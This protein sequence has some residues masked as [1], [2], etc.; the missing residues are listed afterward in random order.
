ML[1]QCWTMLNNVEQC[2]TMSNNVE[3]CWTMLSHVK[4]CWAMLNDVEPCWTMLNHVESCWTRLLCFVQKDVV[5]EFENCRTH[6]CHERSYELR[7]H[8]RSWRVSVASSLWWP[9]YTHPGNLPLQHWAQYCFLDWKELC[10]CFLFNFQ[11]WNSMPKFGRETWKWRTEHLYMC[12]TSK[13]RKQIV[14]NEYFITRR[15]GMIWWLWWKRYHCISRLGRRA[16][17]PE[18][19]ASKRILGT[20][21]RRHKEERR[22]RNNRKNRT[23]KH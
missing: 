4:P 2:W 16:C 17:N 6:W 8:W 22:S 13:E 3:Q 18:E 9:W 20:R 14:W 5:V 10:Y 19:Q 12:S 1:E 23:A 21:W 11:V 7:G 15:C